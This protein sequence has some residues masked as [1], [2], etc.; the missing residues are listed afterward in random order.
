MSLI[1]I[2]TKQFFGD[3]V[4]PQDQYSTPDLA[5]FITQGTEYVLFNL[6]G[7][8]LQNLAENDATNEP[9]KSLLEGKEYTINYN[10]QERK[11]KWQGLKAIDSEDKKSLISYYVYSEFMRNRV[12]RTHP[13]GE[14]RSIT[15]NSTN[16]DIMLKVMSA[17]TKFEKFYGY[18]GQN[19]LIPSAYNFIYEHI[20][21]YP[22][23][24]FTDLR[25]SINS[26]DL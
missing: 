25:G 21:N 24:E 7:Y 23:W 15:E 22:E 3:I 14:K 5:L 8:T 9:Y 2:D 17:F 20:D 26:H 6:L 1:L 18:P 4:L 12:T 13:V 11:V 19:K 16:A 10:G